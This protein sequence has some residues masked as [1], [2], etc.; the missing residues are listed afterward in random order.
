MPKN[1]KDHYEKFAGEFKTEDELEEEL[2]DEG[3]DAE[4]VEKEHFEEEL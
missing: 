3:L 1:K 4:E 2:E